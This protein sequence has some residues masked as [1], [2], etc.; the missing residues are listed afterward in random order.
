LRAGYAR[1]FGENSMNVVRRI[2]VGVAAVAVVALAM[3][4]A[5]PKAV[6]AV[7]NLFVTVTNTP[8][9]NVVNAPS[10]NVA[11]TV[12][13]TGTVAVSSLPAVQL[14]GSV[15]ATVSNPSDVNGSPVPLATQDSAARTGFDVG[16]TCAFGVTFNN[17]CGIR[18]IYTVPA[19]YIAVIQQFSGICTTNTGTVPS[20]VELQYTGSSSQGGTLTLSPGTQVPFSAVQTKS[21]YSQRIVGYAFGGSSGSAI[22]VGIDT[23]T[24]QGGNPNVCEI[25]IAGYLIHQ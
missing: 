12:P 19:N 7:A 17:F 3:T 15:N 14:G 2:V 24:S 25:H 22:N 9:V 5:A 21:V 11:N 13:V 1:I 20:D 23:E 6:H 10:V 18:P 4:L 16:G 8:N